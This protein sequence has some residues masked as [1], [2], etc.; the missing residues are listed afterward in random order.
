MQTYDLKEHSTAQLTGG[1]H[2]LKSLL[3]DHQSNLGAV[4]PLAHTDSMQVGPYALGCSVHPGFMD[5]DQF[6]LGAVTASPPLART[7]STQLGANSMQ[8]A[9]EVIPNHTY[10]KL[11]KEHVA[12]IVRVLLKKS[13]EPQS[14]WI[15]KNAI[16]S[17]QF[18]NLKILALKLDNLCPKC[19]CVGVR[20]F[21][22]NRTTGVT[23]IS[24][25]N[26]LKK[27]ERFVL[28][29]CQ[30][31]NQTSSRRK[32]QRKNGDGNEGDT[33][34]SQSSSGPTGQSQSPSSQNSGSSGSTPSSAGS[35]SFNINGLLLAANEAGEETSV[36][37]DPTL[38][39][40]QGANTSES[41]DRPSQPAD[42]AASPV[43][44][45]RN[46][47]NVAMS[48]DVEDKL[49]V[50]LKIEGGDESVQ[51]DPS[52][53]VVTQ[54]DDLAQ[55]MSQVSVS[56]AATPLREAIKMPSETPS[57]SPSE[58]RLWDVL[59]NLK[60]S[61]TL[62]R[63]IYEPNSYVYPAK[64]ENPLA[65]DL[66]FPAG[67]IDNFL[68]RDDIKTR[69]SKTSKG[70]LTW[71]GE[72]TE[73]VWKSA[74]EFLAL[75][76]NKLPTSE[77]AKL[78]GNVGKAPVA[79][80]P[81]SPTSGSTCA[82][83]INH[84]NAKGV[85]LYFVNE[86]ESYLEKVKRH[87]PFAERLEFSLGEVNDLL[88]VI[89]IHA[90]SSLTKNG[91]HFWK[92]AGAKLAWDIA[93]D[94]SKKSEAKSPA[95]AQ[96]PAK[97]PT[98]IPSSPTSKHAWDLL[99][100]DHVL[101]QAEVFHAPSDTKAATPA[102]AKFL[103]NVQTPVKVPLSTPSS[104]TYKPTR[105]LFINH[106]KPTQGV[107][108]YENIR[109]PELYMNEV[110][111]GNP[112]AVALE[113]PTGQVDTAVQV[114]ELSHNTSLTSHG[115]RTW[116]PAGTKLHSPANAETSANPPPPPYSEIDLQ[117]MPAMDSSESA[118]VELA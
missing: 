4:P 83:L 44:F 37:I 58:R 74:I 38:D 67:Q 76:D 104:S 63:N 8:Q 103:A 107:T 23:N 102:N 105:T 11:V 86:P 97:A 27:H 42:N 12:I 91:N 61:M 26:K 7:H 45:P 94:F 92:D 41:P 15:I 88:Q 52:R 31:A 35:G 68:E 46:G 43:E 79:F 24:P 98:S 33:P 6:N 64:I 96:T 117:K 10:A 55:C 81:S 111:K 95:K 49:A 34:G 78:P 47:K 2:L 82:L 110:K 62:Y 85:T 66:Q 118:D 93:K 1:K 73:F 100:T 54:V 112:H 57:T 21:K 16:T 17:T 40:T 113:I 56:D 5:H 13:R 3:F 30:K 22:K 72:N 108:M 69:T 90:P 14:D 50:A 80:T 71:K 106:N 20:E 32:K 101:K 87:S 77:N 65:E 99:N 89:E 25:R 28:C 53:V 116:K 59:V 9:P 39:E 36:K 115:N 84:N 29:K 51:P 18:T 19:H 70:N 48:N 75:S 114:I 60:Q 109:N